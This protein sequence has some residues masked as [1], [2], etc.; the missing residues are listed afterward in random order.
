[1]KRVIL[2]VIGVISFSCNAQ[3]D[4]PQW[5]EIAEQFEC[6][7]WF[8]DAKF[9]IWTHWGPQTK[10]AVGG[11]WYARSMYMTDVGRETWGKNAYPY[12]VQQY[13][14]PSEI[15]FKDVIHSWKAKNLDTDS[16]MAFFK[17]VGAR[18]FVS[19]ANHHDHFDNF[20]SSYHPWNSVNIG[21]KRDI[22]GEF[23]KSARKYGLYY[24][25]SSHDDRFMSWWLPAFGADK[26]GPKKG[27]P[28][29]GH[30]TKEDGIGKWWEG[31]DPADLYGL[32]PEKRTPEWEKKIKENWM[33]RHLELVNKYDLDLLWYDGYNFPY[34]E[35][36]KKVSASFYN[37]SLKKHGKIKSVINVKGIGKGVVNDI[38]R[39]LA[40]ELRKEPWQGN[41]TFT[42]WFYKMDKPERHNAR[43]ILESLIEAVSKNGNLLVS[44]E[45]YPDGT[46]V[47]EQ[48][49]VM[50]KVGNWLKINGEAIYGTRPWKVFGD[51][52]SVHGKRVIHS[53]AASETSEEG[54]KEKEKGE[55]FNERTVT[56]ELYEPNEVRYTTKGNALYLIV[57]N[58]ASGELMVPSLGF[59]AM[60]A[61]NKIKKM[62]M[63]GSNTKIKYEQ[64]NKYLK[65]IIQEE[66]LN[67][68]PITFKLT[69]VL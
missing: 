36:G 8:R 21:P 33:Q 28:Y 9:G 48:K 41:L 20:N 60:T 49:E 66:I 15:G 22:V 2:I 35:Y 67:K 62:E 25:T 27:I 12:H 61:P 1:M 24:G 5:D 52:Y 42:G 11:G 37:K 18:Y 59:E 53:G 63:L 54:Q 3:T 45:L 30:M 6:P 13:G 43:T 38:E 16:L 32:P 55:H 19:M 65:I 68:R 31:Y 58:P 56:A 46:I 64:G 39:G 69:G 17:E 51:G 7:E 40:T 10:P 47:R 44:V 23:G 50:K 29:D 34:G 26:E 14:H 57:L 4:I